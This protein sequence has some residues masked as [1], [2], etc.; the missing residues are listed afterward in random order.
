MS[1]DAMDDGWRRDRMVSLTELAPK[2]AKFLSPDDAKELQ[3]LANALAE[4]VSDPSLKASL[5]SFGGT[6]TN[7]R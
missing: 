5:E 2:A 3:D 6:I 4:E 1:N 7:Q